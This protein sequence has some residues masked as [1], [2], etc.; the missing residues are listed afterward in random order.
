MDVY[1]VL[2]RGVDRRQI[3]LEEIDYV[4]FVHDMYEFNDTKPARNTSVRFEKH[5][6]ETLEIDREYGTPAYID[7]GRRYMRDPLVLIHAYCLMPNHCHLMMSE[8]VEGGI[9]LFMKKLGGGYSKYFNEKYNRDGALWQG[10]YKRILLETD[11]HF[12]HL[13]FYIHANPLDLSEE[14]WREASVKNTEHALALLSKHRWSSH[15]DYMGVKNFPSVIDTS[16]L[17]Q[18]FTE[19][20]GYERAITTFL[21]DREKQGALSGVTLE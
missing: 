7:V 12:Q 9:S 15:L 8:R 1:H 10:K 20:G 13:P 11:T 5:S 14:N 17:F 21:K 4:R 3:F 2:N 16:L 19:R 6:H 18:T